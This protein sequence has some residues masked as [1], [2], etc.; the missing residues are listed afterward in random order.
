MHNLAQNGLYSILKVNCTYAYITAEFLLL[1]FIIIL[2]FLRFYF[3][4]M[5]IWLYSCL[6]L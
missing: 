1:K 4:L 3:L 5:Y 2:V 6:I